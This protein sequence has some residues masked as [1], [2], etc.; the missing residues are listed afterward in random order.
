MEKIDTG[1]YSMVRPKEGHE[2]ISFVYHIRVENLPAE[3]KH[4]IAQEIHRLVVPFWLDL[5]ASDDVVRLFF[6]KE[7]AHGQTGFP[8]EDEQYMALLPEWLT[9]HSCKY[10]ITEVNT[11]GEFAL[12]ANLANHLLA[13]RWTHGYSSGASLSADRPRHDALLPSFCR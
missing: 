3:K 10:L 13:G 8:D 5:D 2:G 7:K 11:A 9:G 6:G 12:W 4:S 1:T